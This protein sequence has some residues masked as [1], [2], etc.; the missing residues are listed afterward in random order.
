MTAAL[1]RCWMKR[2]LFVVAVGLVA[3]SATQALYPG[4]VW[5]G[6]AVFVAVVWLAG[7][8]KGGLAA[9]CLGAFLVVSTEHT[10]ERQARD[11]ERFAAMGASVA[12]GR[13]TE[14]GVGEGGRWS[15]VVELRGELFGG[16]KVKWMGAG[17]APPAGTQVIAN[18]VFYRLE[19]ERNPG[20]P[21]RS[22]RLRTQGV[23]AVFRASEMRC[24]QWIAPFPQRAAAFKKSFREGI[25]AGLDPECEEAKVIRAVVI[26]E[27]AQ[28]SLELVRS[29]R[30]S[31]TLHVFTVSGLHVA[32]LG[33][34]IW[35]VLK[36]TGVRRRWAVPLIIVAMFG[37]VWLT[38]NGQAAVRAAW[39][40][41][42]FL[43]AFALRRRS[44]LL[45]SL[46]VVLLVALVWDNRVIRMPGVQLSYG[47][48]ASIGLLTVF[49]RRCFTWIAAV[50]DFLPVSE[51][52]W[53]QRKWL[54]VR[55]KLADAL[56]VSTAASIGSTP[57]GMF[58][59]GLF[60][61]VSVLATV[62]L[63]PLVY[64]LLMAAIFSSAVYPFWKTG[65]VILNRA[66]FCLAWACSE[67]AEFFADM[68]GASTS[69]RVPERDVL[70]IYD[71]QYGA[72]ASC[73]VPAGGNAVMI[74]TGGK[75]DLESE[76]GFSMRQLGME[77]DSVI[78]TH[79][80]A[81]HMAGPELVGTMFP[82]RQV[83]MGGHGSPGSVAVKWETFSKKGMETMQPH[84]GDR[85]DFGGGVW[86]EVLLSP[87]DE[88]LGPVA[89]DRALVFMMHWQG[90]KILWLGDAG[91]FSEVAMI[92]SGAELKADV[93]VAGF[94]ESDT[95]LTD[96]F[97]TAVNPQAIVLP[98][99]PG[100]DM[101]GYRVI[102]TKGWR[103][104]HITVIEQAAAGGLTV[105]VGADGSL[106]IEGFYDGSKTVLTR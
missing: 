52:G 96:E 26:G 87:H 4:L 30:E 62:A 53:W 72:G 97:I 16:R 45:N 65:S 20:T 91:R 1:K 86:G 83:A 74:D 18:G 95:S 15:A 48:V 101:D 47:V 78:F 106:L 39:M 27:R 12:E 58:H 85:L 35:F 81:G 6:V 21:D 3:V 88:I 2:P 82:L 77:P 102:R 57:L 59:F 84:K 79:A 31:G 44:D 37:Y 54:G 66:N 55:R 99:P 14:D 9:A 69:T 61:P 50:D 76:V 104:K 75:R 71:L 46:G 41:A 40:G 8:W 105:T 98:S 60:T 93:I 67:T 32:M 17:E 90:W 38:G 42:V 24:E 89:D 103:K 73:F 94:H 80:D 68:P 64:L 22:E 51:M 5:L 23:V 63:V 13:L 28:D 29:F 7:G 92:N 36:W 19:R 49:T 43:G 11:E 10:D 33:S 56:A 25:V 34:I 70:V 100:S